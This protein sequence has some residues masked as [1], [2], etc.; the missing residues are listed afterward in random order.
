MVP[1]YERNGRRDF[2]AQIY[3]KDEGSYV[4]I[5]VPRRDQ[6]FKTGSPSAQTSHRMWHSAGRSG[7]SLG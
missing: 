7:M 5:F 2:A 3:G 6:A 1:P 4:N